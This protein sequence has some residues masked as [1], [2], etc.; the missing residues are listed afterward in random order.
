[1]LFVN[2]LKTLITDRR[3]NLSFVLSLLAIFIITAWIA[4]RGEL[5]PNITDP[6]EGVGVSVV[7]SFQYFMV[8]LVVISLVPS[9]RL[10]FLEGP[11]RTTLQVLLAVVLVVLFMVLGPLS[12]LVGPPVG[13]ALTFCDATITAYFTVLLGWNIGR[14]THDKLGPRHQPNW[15]LFLLF[16][17]FAILTFGGV[18]MLLGLGQLDISQQIVLLMFP[19]GIVILP[20]F[21]VL[22][23]KK[24]TGPEQTTMMTLVLFLIGLY[25]T[26]RLTNITD[27]RFTIAD[28]VLQLL[29]M[30]YGLSTTV[31]KNAERVNVT[32]IVSITLVLFVILSRV[33]AYVNR[34]LAAATGWGDIVQV[35]ITSFTILNLAII[36]L[37]APAVWMWRARKA[38][39]Q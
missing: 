34:L 23:R 18:Y 19:L 25:Y 37:L 31:A 21:T 10:L 24:G 12:A 32:P 15:L 39:P 9:T 27:S 11:R 1:M 26:F 38:E 3:Y 13:A 20:I 35:G 36:G 14:S 29:L 6:I 7:V 4:I 30:V 2:G 28:L 22:L 17:L 8:S 33:G 16:W 5:D